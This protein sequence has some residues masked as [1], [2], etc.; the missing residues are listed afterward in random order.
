MFLIYYPKN[1]DAIYIFRGF[2]I[3]ISTARYLLSENQCYIVENDGIG[4]SEKSS[5][6]KYSPS[7]LLWLHLSTQ[8]IR[9]WIL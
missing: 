3:I 1:V 6:S 5:V 2:L 7:Q 9:S 4:V 8:E